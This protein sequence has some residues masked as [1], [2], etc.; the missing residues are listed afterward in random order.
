MDSVVY[1][2]RD[3][4]RWNGFFFFCFNEDANYS[5]TND[6]YLFDERAKAYVSLKNN[7]IAIFSK[8]MHAH[9]LQFVLSLIVNNVFIWSPNETRGG[10]PLSLPFNFFFFSLFYVVIIIPRFSWSF[11]LY[12]HSLWRKIYAH[13][14]LA[15][16][17]IS[18]CSMHKSW[19]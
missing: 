5:I 10:R 2:W 15:C 11:S 14:T 1:L 19:G 4:R 13:I 7:V 18:L 8:C 16:Q 9:M 6:F 12:F 17:Y 3:K